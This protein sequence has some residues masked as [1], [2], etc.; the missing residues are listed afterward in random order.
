[1]AGRGMGMATKGGGCVG[2]GPRNKMVKETSK[3]TGPVMMNKGGI[4]QKKMG[5]GMMKKYRNG[6]SA[7]K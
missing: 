6:G 1:M 2:T 3:T 4:A 7:C 5:G